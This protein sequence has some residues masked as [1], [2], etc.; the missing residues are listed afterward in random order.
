MLGGLSVFPAVLPLA[1][2]LRALKSTAASLKG[3]GWGGSG[4][5]D[6]GGEDEG[7]GEMHG[8]VWMDGK[9]LVIEEVVDFVRCVEMM[10]WR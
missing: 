7:F 3:L 5:G 10:A 4:A 6:G 9:N 8:E 1:I 2:V